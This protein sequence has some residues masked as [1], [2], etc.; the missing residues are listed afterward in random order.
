MVSVNSQ[1]FEK[2]V[3]RKILSENNGSLYNQGHFTGE[4][5]EFEVEKIW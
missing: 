5:I 3:L 2:L 1:I 4:H